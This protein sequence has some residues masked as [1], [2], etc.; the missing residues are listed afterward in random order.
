MARKWRVHP[1]DPARVQHLERAAG[2][3][4][5]A[6]QLLICRGI[7]DAQRAHAF[8]NPL[9][10]D[11]H[12]PEL[13]PG[14]IAA[15]DFLHQAVTDRRKIVVYGDYDVD[16]MSGTALLV[17]CLKLLGADVGYY[18]P[19]RIDEGY[20]LGTVA[21]RQLAERGYGVVVTVDCGI[22][23]TSE[24]AL[25][26]ELGLDLIITDHHS[27]GPVL[28]AAR[29][30]VHPALGPV[31]YP[32]AGLCGAAVAFKL[33]WALCQRANRSKRVSQPMRDYLLQALALVALGT[34]ADVVPLVGENRTIVRHGL[35]SLKARP[36]PGVAALA[37]VAKLA[38]KP[39]FSSEDVAFALAPR[40]NA[41]GRLGQAMLGVELLTTTSPERATALAE[42]LHE[43]NGSRESLER[44]VYLAANKQAQE[45]CDAG[46]E[47]LVLSGRGWHPGVIGIVAGRLAEKF[48]RPVILIALDELGVKPGVGSARGVAGFD[49][50]ATLGQCADDLLSHGGHAMAA[51]L[52]IADEQVAAFRAN[53]SRHAASALAS[54]ERADELLIDAE[55]P[56]SGLSMTAVSELEHLAP[57]GHA[58]PRPLLCTSGVTLM[59]PP[60][61]IGAGQRHLSLR[62]MQH[63]IALK[64]VAFGAADWATP[65]DAEASRS[66]A[67]A[68]RPMIN[69][70][71]GRRTV[72]L[73]VCDWRPETRASGVG[74]PAAQPAA[75]GS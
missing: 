12:E 8:L 39:K 74:S 54:V 27:P 61:R 53:F 9:L 6:A 64:G 36:L 67:V 34:V 49:L 18:V 71:R 14:V 4:A 31:P 40:L 58:N 19:N 35:E 10:K 24:A 69:E 59:E 16:G 75:V 46:L 22:A 7:A 73:Q 29:A 17:G 57:F 38:D 47:A 52:K 15:A 63:G 60:R 66:I 62:L 11:L 65:L 20:G 70:F 30:I 37:A 33:A 55:V 48:H 43:L 45:Q 26:T 28:P 23:S 56:F 3:S 44:S 50:Y 25:A 72:E 13:L 32:F 5:V 21:L 68:Y 2:I 41:A 1:H 42:Y 51:G